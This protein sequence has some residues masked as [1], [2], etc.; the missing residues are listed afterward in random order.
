MA[1]PATP[2]TSP[3]TQNMSNVNTS[4]T[5]IPRVVSWSLIVS[6]PCYRRS[7]NHPVR[8]TLLDDFTVLQGTRVLKDR[9]VRHNLC[10]VT[11]G[12][13]RKQALHS[14]LKYTGTS[15]TPGWTDTEPGSVFS[16]NG[17]MRGTQVKQTSSRRCAIYKRTSPLLR[18]RQC[19]KRMAR[20]ATRGVS[21]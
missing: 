16:F 5:L 21:M 14:I 15:E 11:E 9:E 12:A 4:C 6:L 10:Y 19:A 1:Y 7:V 17:P 8:S 3:P 20:C 13:P 2:P 18:V